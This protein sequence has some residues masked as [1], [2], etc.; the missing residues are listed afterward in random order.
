MWMVPPLA[1]QTAQYH[2][3]VQQHNENCTPDA[4]LH[5]H[6]VHINYAFSAAQLR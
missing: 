6:E 2:I 4:K 1:V 5:F 3:N